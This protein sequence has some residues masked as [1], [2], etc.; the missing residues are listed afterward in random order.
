MIKED[1]I[2]YLIFL[3]IFLNTYTNKKIEIDLKESKMGFEK[4]RIYFIYKLLDDKLCKVY[5]FERWGSNNHPVKPLNPIHFFEA[6]QRNTYCR[7]WMYEDDRSD[8]LVFFEALRNNISSTTIP[9]EKQY[10]NR[11]QFFSW[12]YGK[13]GSEIQIQNVLDYNSFLINLPNNAHFIL[14]N[15]ELIRSCKYIYS[16]NGTLEKVEIKKGDEI[17]GTS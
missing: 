7:A 12:E 14:S 3:I 8:Q 2:I 16:L 4:S 13:I 17:I 5:F 9:I 1:R 6:I 10:K 15:L 11:L